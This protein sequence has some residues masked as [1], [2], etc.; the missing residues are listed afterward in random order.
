MQK[1][2]KS[3]LCKEIPQIHCNDC[4]V[5]INYELLGYSYEKLNK[6]ISLKKIVYCKNCWFN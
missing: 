2:I 1:E 3:E 5:E 4:G 6:G